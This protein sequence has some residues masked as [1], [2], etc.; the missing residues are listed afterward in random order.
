L[1]GHYRDQVVLGLM[2]YEGLRPGEIGTFYWNELLDEDGV[3][4]TEV[5]VLRAWSESPNGGS[6]EVPF[7]KDGEYRVIKIFEPLRADITQFYERCGRPPLSSRAII[8]Q[9]GMPLLAGP[10]SEAVRSRT[11]SAGLPKFRPYDLR[12]TA[13]S[14]LH[15]GGD[16]ERPGNGWAV[17]E[18]ARHLGHSIDVCTRTYL[19]VFKSPSRFRGVPIE[20][21]IAE[22]RAE[23]VT[24]QPGEP[25][26]DWGARKLLRRYR[27]L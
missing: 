20:L 22:C 4:R 21:V 17:S 10:L 18:L 3:C 2:A 27:A 12:H 7:P 26:P 1:V 9:Y 8:N 13:A 5:E 11:R 15:A 19:H 14:L 16:E 25:V 24:A 23:A 6:V